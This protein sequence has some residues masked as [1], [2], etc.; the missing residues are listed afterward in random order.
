MSAP[1]VSYFSDKIRRVITLEDLM[2]EIKLD[3]CLLNY[4][5]LG[6]M[7]HMFEINKGRVMIM[8]AQQRDYLIARALEIE[9]A[10][11]EADLPLSSS[12]ASDIKDKF[13]DATDIGSGKYRLEVEG[14]LGV[15]HCLDIMGDTPVREAKSKTFLVLPAS[16]AVLYES[17]SPHF[18]KDVNDKFSNCKFEIDE[19]AKCLAVGRSTATVFHLM[20]AMEN[21]LKSVAACLSVTPPNTRNWGDWLRIIR[22][23]R[24]RR[25]SK[26]AENDL[27]Q[28]IWQRLDA[29]KDAQRNPT[30][31]VETIYTE[32]E[33]K[34]IYELTKGFMKKIASRM[35]ENGQPLA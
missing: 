11:S 10:F 7:S 4:W 22:E 29:V 33:A 30:M 18:G 13:Q 14:L 23:E 26:W 35:D 21:V 5:L 15:L 2:R 12:L 31:H 27:F 3:K 1:G 34:A 25:G 6:Q 32:E 16:D 9:Q 20:R 17:K 19:A 8:P 24:L 28:D